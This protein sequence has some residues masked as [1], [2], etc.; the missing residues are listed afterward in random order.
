MANVDEMADKLP[1]IGRLGACANGI[2]SLKSDKGD[3]GLLD[4]AADEIERLRRLVKMAYAEGVIDASCRGAART[5]WEDFWET[6][7]VAQCVTD[8]EAEGELLTHTEE[9]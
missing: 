4:D 9:A 8:A 3:F 5:T 6:S 2:G 1:L 7:D